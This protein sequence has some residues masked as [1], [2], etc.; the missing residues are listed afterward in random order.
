V[1]QDSQ[2]LNTLVEGGPSD[3][4][5]SSVLGTMKVLERAAASAQD[6][7]ENGSDRIDT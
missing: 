4:D 3:Y 7:L 6:L 2:M 1:A 5:I